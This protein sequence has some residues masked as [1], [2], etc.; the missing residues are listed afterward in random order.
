MSRIAIHQCLSNLQVWLKLPGNQDST[1]R[2]YQDQHVDLNQH[3]RFFYVIRLSFLF[4]GT[5]K[6]IYPQRIPANAIL[7]QSSDLIRGTHP[8]WLDICSFP[9]VS[10]LPSFACKSLIPMVT[11]TLRPLS[12]IISL[13]H[14]AL[15]GAL[16]IW[17][18]VHGQ[19]Y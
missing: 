16:T 1:F 9:R 4:A 8:Y 11:D 2:S 13:V 14:Q 17:S 10:Y 18:S 7:L 15:P 12:R 19:T 3:Q 6:T 5:P